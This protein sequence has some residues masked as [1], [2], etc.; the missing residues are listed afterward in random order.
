MHRWSRLVGWVVNGQERN[1]KNE[2]KKERRKEE[3]TGAI[4]TDW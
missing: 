1:K 4:A 2:K 3:N